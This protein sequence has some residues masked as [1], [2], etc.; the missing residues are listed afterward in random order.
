ML[1][2]GTTNLPLF[3]QFNRV[4]GPYRSYSCLHTRLSV[5]YIITLKTLIIREL[6]VLLLV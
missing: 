5:K 2:A 3:I 4:S 6:F 1:A